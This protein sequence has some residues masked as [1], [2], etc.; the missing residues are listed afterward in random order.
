MI[1]K[2]G[3]LA[4]RISALTSDLL[5]GHTG[6]THYL[7]TW[8]STLS[9]HPEHSGTPADKILALTS[10]LLEGRMPSTQDVLLVRAAI[11][12]VSDLC[13]C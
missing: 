12:Q 13:S 2:A 4:D 1:N 7:P 10:D 3:T 9:T 11:L 6:L 5:E 8:S